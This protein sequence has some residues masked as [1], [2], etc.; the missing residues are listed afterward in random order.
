MSFRFQG[1]PKVS[2]PC[3]FRFRDAPV[4]RP[5]RR[6]TYA[7]TKS[8]AR[9][10]K[11]VCQCR[12]LGFRGFCRDTE[13]HLGPGERRTSLC[14]WEGCPFETS[15]DQPEKRAPPF[16]TKSAGLRLGGQQN[17]SVRLQ[18]VSW[19]GFGA[20]R[21]CAHSCSLRFHD[22]GPHFSKSSTNASGSAMSGHWGCL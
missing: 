17:S 12:A 16:S 7:G 14:F 2:S 4:L 8:R 21:P 20:G 22:K 18:E 1:P 13:N 19:V 10:S 15:S 11:G 5:V 9:G 3:D 6:W